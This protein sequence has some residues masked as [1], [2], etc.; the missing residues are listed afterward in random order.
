MSK[1]GKILEV[2]QGEHVMGDKWADYYAAESARNAGMIRDA[3]RRFVAVQRALKNYRVT[4][5]RDL[6]WNANGYIRV[7]SNSKNLEV[8]I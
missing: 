7:R 4:V 8:Y 5:T 3:H 6:E 1:L 2:I